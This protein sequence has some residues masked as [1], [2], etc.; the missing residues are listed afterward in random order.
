MRLRVRKFS[1]RWLVDGGL[2][3][4]CFS[5]EMLSNIPYECAPVCV[6]YILYTSRLDQF[7]FHFRLKMKYLMRVNHDFRIINFICVF[8]FSCC[9]HFPLY[10]FWGPRGKHSKRILPSCF[11]GGFC[12][13]QPFLI[14]LFHLCHQHIPP[15]FHRPVFHRPFIFSSVEC[16]WA[17][18]SWKIDFVHYPLKLLRIKTH[19]AMRGL[20]HSLSFYIIGRIFLYFSFCV[21]VMD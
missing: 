12:F 14:W 2:L 4:S 1:F 21:V 9:S 19:S 11:F 7:F 20:F 5:T 13:R 18:L 8:L 10:V 3:F 15:A 17:N 6:L 16:N